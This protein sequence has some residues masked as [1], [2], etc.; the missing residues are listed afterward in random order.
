MYPLTKLATLKI[1]LELAAQLN[2]D[3]YLLYFHV[4]EVFFE[5][6]SIQITSNGVFFS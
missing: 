3:A 5:F 4:S 2:R 6:F 1:Q